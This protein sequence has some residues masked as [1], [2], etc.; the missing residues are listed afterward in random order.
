MRRTIESASGSEGE[1]RPTGGLGPRAIATRAAD[2]EALEL[3][4]TTGA[5]TARDAVRTVVAASTTIG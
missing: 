5:S 3:I 4:A 1:T 2:R